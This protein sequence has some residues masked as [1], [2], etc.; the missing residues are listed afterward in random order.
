MRARDFIIEDDDGLGL[1]MDTD[2]IEDHAD[3]RGDNILVDQLVYLQNRSSEMGHSVPRVSVK[4]LIN[5]VRNAGAEMFNA[6][7]LK[8]AY[9]QNDSVK[10]LI[11]NIE[12]DENGEEYV[13]LEPYDDSVTGD[14]DG[15]D[16]GMGDA[17]LGD[18]DKENKTVAAMASRAAGA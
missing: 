12:P 2:G 16:A 4:T 14:N 10:N 1:D 17:G 8:D 3:V 11:K 13:Y 9:S 5:Q 7:V 6:K 15:G 18:A